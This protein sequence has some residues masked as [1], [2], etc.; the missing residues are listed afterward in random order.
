MCASRRSTS[1][2]SDSSGGSL[3]RPTPPQV[4]Q[5]T[6]HIFGA[7][8]SPTICVY[9]LRRTA[10]DNAADF[11]NVYR[12]VLENF[13]VDN[14]LNSVETEETA[15]EN[16]EELTALLARGGFPLTQWLSSSRAFLAKIPPE[17]R[18][19]PTLN[20]D[21]DELPIERTLGIIWDAGRDVFQFV[22]KKE[23]QP[24]AYTKRHVLSQTLSVF[25]PLGFVSPVTLIP[26]G[27]IQDLWRQRDLKWDDPLPDI[28]AD[29]WQKW[30][31]Q[32]H[33][34]EAVRVPRSIKI[35]FKEVVD[36][37]LH[38][39]VDASTK[40]FGAVVYQRTVYTDEETSVQLVMSKARIAPLKFL[41]IPRMELQA[42]VV[43]LRVGLK[44]AEELRIPKTK[45]WFWSDSQTVLQWINSTSRRYHVFVANR[46]AEI[47]D[48]TS[49]VQWRHVPGNLN[50]ADE[51]SRGSQPEDFVTSDTW[52]TG[53][54]FLRGPE[55][56]WPS[57]NLQLD[58]EDQEVV[59]QH[60]I[61]ATQVQPVA[62]KSSLYERI[63]SRYSE[64]KKAVRTVAWI[65]RLVKPRAEKTLNA[66]EIRRARIACIKMSQ[67]HWFA[68]EI[69]DLKR[70]RQIDRTSSL[71]KHTPYLD[72]DGVLRVG[73]RIDKAALDHERRH[74]AILHP[75][76]KLTQA[77][78]REEHHEH[79]CGVEQLLARLRG[80]V[81]ILDPRR[82]IRNVLR[83]CFKCQKARAQPSIPLMAA[84]PKERLTDSIPP[85]TNTG[86]DCFGP[87]KVSVGRRLEKRWVCLFTCL[88]TRAL[89]L[90]V[91][92]QMSTDSF[93]MAWQRFYTRH[94][95]P[96]TLFC[97][98]GKNFVGGKRIMQDAEQTRATRRQKLAEGAEEGLNHDLFSRKLA[99]EGVE[100]KFSPPA[101]P[102][103]GGVWERLVKSC[104]IAIEIEIGAKT[105]P[106]E[107]F[108]T[109]MA[110]VEALLNA[111]PLTH[112]SV[113]PRDLEPITPNH[114]VYGR[115]IS[116]KPLVSCDSTDLVSRQRIKIVQ[117]LV[118]AIWERW[119]KEYLPNLIERKKWQMERENLKVNDIVLMISENTPRGKWPVGKVVDVFVSSDGIVRSANVKVGGSVY[120]RPVA[121][122]CILELCD[123]PTA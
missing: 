27:M 48:D 116:Y 86:M 111:R 15:A 8:S 76:S 6:V 1:L 73:G 69:Q 67:E 60:W 61:S 43:G 106:D 72:N 46:I 14:Y 39:F 75:K 22:V 89:H 11:P 9:A 122:L 17:K 58:Q 28:F 40:G 91:I 115:A 38:I 70:N 10:E 64:M 32:L 82:T 12:C 47:L 109:V 95:R 83:W 24:A 29:A 19:Q 34:I 105:V 103:M 80:E 90:E 23:E 56:I 37:N 57:S 50:P 85:F 97:D 41:T 26:K 104:K 53:P 100:W 30:R 44:V 92:H 51:L 2:R 118:Q 36:L 87:F 78:I 108:R 120:K 55:N 96:S 121:K 117:A 77:L 88:G 25:D 81:W 4:Y 66:E 102:H 114:L 3:G 20:L 18:S 45:C 79:H 13:F 107:V 54:E 74:P 123:R 31:K 71:L 33:S 16:A 62:C 101:A 93:L 113:D 49:P 42:A 119:L 7:V 52:F 59:S 5:M 63:F 65:R 21:I 110:D 68:Q 94:G 84:L 35:P 99:D 112:V 98:N